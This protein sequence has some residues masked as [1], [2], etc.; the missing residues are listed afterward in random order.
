MTKEDYIKLIYETYYE[1]INGYQSEGNIH[2][3][4]L[5]LEIINE[6]TE[7]SGLST[8]EQF[9]TVI[10]EYM[11]AVKAI[12]KLSP[13]LSTG[14][15]DARVKTTIITYSG[16][17]SDI[18]NDEEISE[19]TVF[20]ASSMTKMFTAILLLKKHER[21][22]IDLNKN[23]SDYSPLLKSVDIKII[24][25]LKFGADLKTDGR[26]D[27]KG[28]N[29]DERVKRLLN[30][31][32][33]ERRTFL[34]SDIPYMLVPLL[35]GE[36]VEEATENYLKEI[37]RFYRDEL[38]LTHTGYSTINM[39]GGSLENLRDGYT[40]GRI[41][42]PK[43]N[44]LESEV[45]YVSGHAGMTTTVKDLIKLFK[46][47][48]SGVLTKESMEVLT[49]T[50]QPYAK[51]LLDENNEPVL[52][53]GNPITLNRGMGVYI[54]AGSLRKGDIYPKYSSSTFASA[55]STGTYAVFDLENRICAIHLS[56]TK[57]GIY[58]KWA[59]TEE[60]TYGDENDAMP[61]NHG[62]TIISGTRGKY[63]GGLIRPD[64]TVMLYVR[65]TNN[66]KKEE[67]QAILKLRVVK[68]V[69]IKR[70]MIE[71]SGKELERVLE[72][73]EE[74]FNRTI[75]SKQKTKNFSNS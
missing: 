22:E 39:T 56:N 18:P 23:F 34:Y 55:G 37:Y 8:E 32:V 48:L 73:I 13:G 19:E 62:A 21:G 24:D 5:L 28:I 53:N 54:N 10:E 9:S 47:L 35:F 3:E 49:T 74:S 26:V 57:S 65:A 38:G 60:Y 2:N 16:K 71:Y 59:N 68:K 15:Y 25:A 30:S 45:G 75:I 51:Q 40:R 4:E 67:F 31:Y 44:L 72:E 42:D 14:L 29:P 7:S 41:Y 58:H 46:H 64:G 20:D 12:G 27:E 66:F 17:M 1:T 36:T 52:R 63:D 33:N 50:S 69:L 43:A 6:L 61:R 70:A 11:E